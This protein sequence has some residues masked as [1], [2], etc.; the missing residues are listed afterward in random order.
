MRLADVGVAGES[1]AFIEV[2]KVVGVYRHDDGRRKL[3]EVGIRR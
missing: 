1:Q 2:D 3:K